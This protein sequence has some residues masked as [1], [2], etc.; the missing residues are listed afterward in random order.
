MVVKSVLIKLFYRR[1]L[2]Y[3]NFGVVEALNETAYGLRLAVRGT[4]YLIL[5]GSDN[6]ADTVRSL[7]QEMYK[8]PQISFIP[9]TLS[10]SQWQSSFKMEVISIF[11]VFF[12]AF[13]TFNYF[14]CLNF[15]KNLLVE[16]FRTT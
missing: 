16:L 7:G 1:L 9:T 5:S 4:H 8:Q 10:F 13:I 2:F 3:D 12:V 15:S 11:N 6:S 14:L